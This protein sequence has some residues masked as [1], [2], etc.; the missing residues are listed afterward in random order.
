MS[1]VIRKMSTHCQSPRGL[2][3]PDSLVDRVATGPLAAELKAQ[4][5]PSL[6]RLPAV[7]RVK[8]LRVRLKI[9]A[10]KLN[11]MSL[12]SAWARALT[13]AIH[14]A[15][16]VP[17]GDGAIASRRYASDAAY[18][19]A[20]IHRIA[21][22]G[23]SPDWEFPELE[24][25]QGYPRLEAC[26]LVL[27]AKRE[28][29]VEILEELHRQRWLEPLLLLW[30]DLS[31]E[32]L[33]QALASDSVPAPGLSF[34]DLIELGRTV[35]APGGMRPQWSLTSRRLA[36]RMWVRLQQRWPVRSIWHGLRLLLK[37]LE[38]PALLIVRDPALLSDA[39][40]F[41]PWCAE[42]VRSIGMIGVAPGDAVVS[43]F[44]GQ[45]LLSRSEAKGRL[46]H[47]VTAADS[48]H[49]VLDAL[50]PLVPSA[51]SLVAPASSGAA[52]NW[53]VSD[54]AGLLLML[55]T[56]RRLGLWRLT[57]TPE[58]VRFGERRALSFLLA[59]LGLNLLAR[60]NLEVPIEPAVAL[61]AGMFEEPDRAGMRQFF[62]E[63]DVRG[64]ADFVQ[65]GTWDEALD[66]GATELARN[67]ASRVRG[68]RQASRDAVVKQFIRVRG[69]VLVEKTRLVV[70]LQPSPWAVALHL[71]SMDEPI[72]RAEWLEERRV[73][74]VL[75][76]L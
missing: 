15:L 27:L 35:A 24:D 9:P 28:M 62:R 40:P 4:L 48:L 54:Y 39:I 10:R 25:W 3:R 14:R 21:T 43:P 74:F 73:D 65:A 71:S 50:R 33:M 20:L 41:P 6:D 56:V 44:I 72:E 7:V 61:F 1:L 17:P 26:L 47:A 67:F 32:R 63:S 23:L 31:L 37:F 19:A 51:A 49:S 13:L 55:S 64:I 8:Q 11:A 45:I 42:I 38:V 36:I 30:D 75:E 52:T 58:F 66:L 16:A 18:Q 22:V 59:G 29:A 60:W 70:V 5:G 2:E 68:F 69:R 57:R 12:A 46:S 53:I 34:D 76:G